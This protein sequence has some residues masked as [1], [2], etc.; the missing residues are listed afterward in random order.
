MKRLKEVKNVS[1]TTKDIVPLN[2]VRARLTELARQV[3]EGSEKIITRNGE[4]Y[5]ALI[6]ARRLDYYHQ[7]EQAHVRLALL[8]EAAKGWSDVEAGRV[9]TV[10]ELRAKYRKRHGR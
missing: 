3:R 8:D 5:V 6:D 7:L 10:A 4:G 2:Q 9:L 1:V